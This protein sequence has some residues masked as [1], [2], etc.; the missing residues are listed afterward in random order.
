MRSQ[1]RDYST[2]SWSPEIS[3]KSPKDSQ[4]PNT[5]PK[6]TLRE[7]LVSLEDLARLPKTIWEKTYKVQ[8]QV[9]TIVWEEVFSPFKKEMSQDQLTQL[10][11]QPR[12]INMLRITNTEWRIRLKAITRIRLPVD[13]LRSTTSL[14]SR[15]EELPYWQLEQEEILR[16]S[17]IIISQAICREEMRTREPCMMFM[18]LTMLIDI[19]IILIIMRTINHLLQVKSICIRNTIIEMVFE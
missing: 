3:D 12:D 7:T 11:T 14:I 6:T 5:I 19:T 15:I 10:E 18:G 1:K 13:Y 16:I 17:L 8:S 9:T 2:Q 4:N